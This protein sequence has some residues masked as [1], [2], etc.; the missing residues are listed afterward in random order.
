[1]QL[2]IDTGCARERGECGTAVSL[3]K[4]VEAKEGREEK[5]R[6]DEHEGRE[7]SCRSDPLRAVKELCRVVHRLERA[8]S[9]VLT[10]PVQV[11]HFVEREFRVDCGK[12]RI[13]PRFLTSQNGKLTVVN[14][15]SI[16]VRARRVI[17]PAVLGHAVDEGVVHAEEAK[18]ARQPRSDCWNGA[19][20]TLARK[21]Y[22]TRG[23]GCRMS[24]TRR[25]AGRSSACRGSRTQTR[26]GGPS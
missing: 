11:L 4:L 24:A 14:I 12:K 6:A 15:S 10:A 8:E 9:V 19:T 26:S 22:H 3:V 21:E 7:G 17:G 25:T 18:R 20:L 5:R 13:S 2:R 23:T 16:A 1:M